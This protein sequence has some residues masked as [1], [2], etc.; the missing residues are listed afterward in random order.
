MK[1][2]IFLT[3]LILVPVLVSSA[4]ALPIPFEL[5]REAEPRVLR[6]HIQS[7]ESN[8]A[9][10]E[11]IR[12][13][14]VEDR[15]RFARFMQRGALYKT[16]IQDIL[17]E[18]GVPPEMYYLAMIES[19]FA[20][21]AR[22][23]A[24]AVGIW[25][26]MRPT[27]RMYGLRVD[28]DVDERLDIIRSTRAAARLLKDLKREFGTWYLAMAAYN[29]GSGRLRRA[30]N[31]NGS[32]D[33]WQLARRDAIPDETANY[34]PKFHAA[35]I[36]ARSPERFGFIRHQYY[37]FPL[38]RRVR[39]AGSQHLSV[40]ARQHKVSLQSLASLNPHLLRGR[41]PR[42]SYEVWIPRARRG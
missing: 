2:A 3:Q 28:N 41:T 19:G 42:S 36:I 26:F 32:R 30:M 31:R 24:R 22:S 23:R 16:L 37:D 11:W 34:V 1:T 17:I 40:I 27:A 20:R 13:F 21:G 33:F 38:V 5:F 4:Q 7:E 8:P 14:S 39:S 15:A 12:Y 10:R 35:M 9:V 25:Q 6:T 29:C 18:N